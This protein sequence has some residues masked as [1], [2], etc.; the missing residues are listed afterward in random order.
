MNRLGTKPMAISLSTGPSSKETSKK[1][2]D[3]KDFE[4]DNS[5]VFNLTSLNNKLVKNMHYNRVK[6]L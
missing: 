3:K 6:W 2:G 5:L 4:K 1:T